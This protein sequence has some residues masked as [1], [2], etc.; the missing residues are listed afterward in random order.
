MCRVAREESADILL[1]HGQRSMRIFVVEAAK[2]RRDDYVFHRPKGMIRGK[3]FLIEYVQSGAGNLAFLQGFDQRIFVDHAA[4]RQIDEVG[5]RLHRGEDRG[6]YDLSSL[7]RIRGKHNEMVESGYGLYELLSPVDTIKVRHCPL[8][9][10]DTDYRH[11][12]FGKVPQ[13]TYNLETH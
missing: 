3:W 10:A 6:V 7:G 12:R 9:R 8:C 2:V 5:C 1:D 4:A 11:P 13:D